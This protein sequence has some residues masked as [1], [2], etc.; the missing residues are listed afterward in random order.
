MSGNGTGSVTVT[1]TA[2]EINAALGGLVYTGILNFHGSDALTI[3]TSDGTSTDTDAIAITVT[4]VN[5]GNGADILWQHDDG[6]P[7]IWLTNGTDAL[8]TANPGE[9]AMW[10]IAWHVIGDGDFNDDDKPDILWQHDNGSA[11]VWLMDGTNIMAH[12]VIDAIST[13]DWNVIG[14]GDFNGDGKSDI[15]WQHD[16]GTP[17]IWLMNG[18]DVIST[19]VPGEA[20]MWSAA[21]HVISSG[22]FNGDGKSDILWQHDDGTPGIWLMNGTDV[23]STA[24]PGQAAMWSTAWHVV[25]A[26]DF[27]G[28]GKSDILWQDDNGSAGVWLMNGASVIAHDIVGS[29]LDTDWNVTGAIDFNDDG[30]ADILWQH[31]DGTPNIWLMDGFTVIGTNTVGPNPGSSWEVKPHHD[32]LI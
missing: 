11:G 31:D 21:W 9:P 1:G 2:A 17:G 3:E 20:A 5:D 29:N 32:L 18:L 8:L 14:S 30:D 26:G 12:D 16:D 22:D 13:P 23:I 19:T 27:N 7:G 24:T 6:T 15:L 28:D 25:G 4:A 10:S